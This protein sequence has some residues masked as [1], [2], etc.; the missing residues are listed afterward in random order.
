M[1][2]WEFQVIISHIF[3]IALEFWI[4]NKIDLL[5]CD[6]FNLIIKYILAWY[7]FCLE[8]PKST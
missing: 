6:E 3:C 8:T 5:K 2:V 1:D 7:L 4:L